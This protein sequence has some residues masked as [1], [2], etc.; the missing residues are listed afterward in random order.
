MRY[1]LDTSVLSELRK[2]RRAAPSVRAWLETVDD[3]ALF[4][5]ALVLGELR[6]GVESIRRRDPV[7][8]VALE[9]WLARLVDQ[10]AERVL[11]VD[12]A[13]ANRWG[14]L[15][16]PDPLPT[17]DGLLAAT[18]LEHGMTLVTRNTQDVERTGVATVNPFSD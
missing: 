16:V 11:K 6:R 10:F 8:A 17:V 5:S 18:A 14:L 12:A 2:G 1:P 3:D 13:T 4:T 9:Q 7:A 15:N